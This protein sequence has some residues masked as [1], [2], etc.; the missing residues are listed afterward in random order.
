VDGLTR[1]AWPT[2]EGTYDPAMHQPLPR[3]Y[4]PTPRTTPSRSRERVGYNRDAV[5]AVLDEAL[6]CHLGV[7]ADDGPLVV[8]TIHARVGEQLYVHGSTGAGVVRIAQARGGSLPVCLTV[9]IVDGLVLA[10]SQFEHSMNYRS[11][12]V[13]GR[14]EVVTDAAERDLALRAI[15]EHVAP[16]RSEHSRP[17]NRRELAA[18][19]V[20]RLPLVEVSL[21]ERSGPPEDDAEDL[22]GPFWA[23]V[24]DVR[25]ETGPVTSAPDL[26]PGIPVPPHVGGYRRP[27]TARPDTRSDRTSPAS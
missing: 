24:V 17:G 6:V 9:T 22:D 15:V 12:V 4:A 16:G 14:A 1:P 7:V 13:R 23:G 11:V 3:R 19:A 27:G 10:R 18:T 20:L 5:H 21:K 8:P 25:T 2:V 26:R